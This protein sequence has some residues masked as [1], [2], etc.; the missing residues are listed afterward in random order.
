MTRSY[1]PI[2]TAYSPH[3]VAAG[4]ASE[5]G[6]HKGRFII[7]KEAEKAH[8]R[9]GINLFKSKEKRMRSRRAFVVG[10]LAT[11]SVSPGCSLFTHAD[12]PVSVGNR[13]ANPIKVFANGAE[14]GDVGAGQTAPF[15]VSLRTVDGP[16]APTAQAQ[17]TFS[18]RDMRTGRLSRQMNWTVYQDR[19]VYVEFNPSDFN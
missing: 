11:L 5:A 10:W 9:S 7:D 8:K 18:A 3:Q 19:P 17:V 13:T 12:F 16:L 4:S 2:L 15:N 1:S 6:P 14:M